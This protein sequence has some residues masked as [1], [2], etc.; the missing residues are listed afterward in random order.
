MGVGVI[1]AGGGGIIHCTAGTVALALCLLAGPN[2]VRSSM[3][4][5][6]SSD[7][8]ES[9]SCAQHVQATFLC[10]AGFAMVHAMPVFDFSR[11]GNTSST[12]TAVRFLWCL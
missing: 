9:S 1:D 12:P 8:V 10:W 5:D 7:L 6:H 4:P 2:T 11:N 3:L